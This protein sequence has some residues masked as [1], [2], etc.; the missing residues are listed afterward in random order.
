MQ[1]SLDVAI[2]EQLARYLRGEMS[3]AE[4]EDWFIPATWNVDQVGNDVARE[5]TYEI[6]LRLA[7]FSYPHWTEA[8]LKELLIPLV[9]HYR[10]RLG[11][12]PR[13]RAH[14]S[15]NV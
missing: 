12:V 14:L 10:M 3:I 2:R 7:E 15:S 6:Q 11:D 4:F 1:P 5:L 13:S 8:E 9:H